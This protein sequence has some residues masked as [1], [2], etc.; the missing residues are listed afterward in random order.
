M[1]ILLELFFDSY[2]R[3]RAS[4]MLCDLSILCVFTETRQKLLLKCTAWSTSILIR[5]GE[6]ARAVHQTPSSWRTAA[7]KT[8]R[9][10]FA[11]VTSSRCEDPIPPCIADV[12]LGRP[13][14][15][16]WAF[17]YLLA[18]ERMSARWRSVDF[19]RP[20]LM[21]CETTVRFRFSTVITGHCH[22]RWR[23][24]GDRAAAADAQCSN[25]VFLATSCAEDIGSFNAQSFVAGMA[26]STYRCS[27]A[28]ITWMQAGDSQSHNP[29]SILSAAFMSQ[30]RFGRKL[31]VGLTLRSLTHRFNRLFV[32]VASLVPPSFRVT[33]KLLS[34]RRHCII[35]AAR[36][37]SSMRGLAD[38]VRS[39]WWHTYGVRGA[40]AQ[41]VSLAPAHCSLA[42]LWYAH[43][44]AT[45]YGSMFSKT[46]SSA[47]FCSAAHSWRH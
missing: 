34:L 28:C 43:S 39:T 13:R 14:D 19:W 32:S 33:T 6:I 22:G 25:D 46:R 38:N 2:H 8:I 29:V 47:A 30:K 1:F 42:V 36:L 5:L 24:C 31:L 21:A 10:D 9:C 20:V 12:E 37:V 7:S 35:G 44:L 3:C 27:K 45:N 18:D 40:D 26:M 15:F 4:P 16:W 11:A 41:L 23:D 17:N